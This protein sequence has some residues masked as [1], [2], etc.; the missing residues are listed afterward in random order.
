MAR[1][2]NVAAVSQELR[3]IGTGIVE[4]VGPSKFTDQIE[5]PALAGPNDTIQI[6][7]DSPFWLGLMGSIVWSVAQGFFGSIG[8]GL[9]SFIIDQRFSDEK[10][11]TDGH[12]ERTL[13]FK[14]NRKMEDASFP[15]GSILFGFKSD[16]ISNHR[17][18]GVEIISYNEFEEYIRTDP[19]LAVCVL[20]RICD[21]VEQIVSRYPDH[22]FHG[23]GTNSDASAKID[24]SEN[25]SA[26]ISLTG[27]RHDGVKGSIGLNILY[28]AI[29]DTVSSKETSM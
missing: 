14:L 28:D 8:E 25:G 21:E 27:V 18:I 13:L 6:L 26:S 17:N 2:V 10:P 15:N 22:F 16:Q 24:V 5:I 11:E 3:D 20:A 7:A 23:F 9:K 1:S 29:G 12:A 4:L 19:T